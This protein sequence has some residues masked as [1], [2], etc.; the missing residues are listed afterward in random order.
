MFF[1]QSADTD[2][3]PE[4]VHTML[5]APDSSSSA[6][7]V[8]LIQDRAWRFAVDRFADRAISF[9]PRTAAPNALA[10]GAKGSGR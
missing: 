5:G 9:P 7:D 2:I 10:R 8:R 3:C 6:A 4:H 1:G